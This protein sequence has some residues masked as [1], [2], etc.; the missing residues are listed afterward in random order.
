MNSWDFRA[1]LPAAAMLAYA[2]AATPDWP[3][4]WFAL[5]GLALWFAVTAATGVTAMLASAK[6][7]AEMHFES[8]VAR[9]R[10]S[11]IEILTDGARLG[12]APFLWMAMAAFAAAVLGGEGIS[13]PAAIAGLALALA[14]LAFAAGLT[15]YTLHVRACE[16]RF[17]T[18]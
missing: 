8:G 7:D 11:W 6:D 15:A 13:E 16:R 10:R 2:L 18:R 9:R 17:R 4:R 14:V 5:A 1:P 3:F 12:A